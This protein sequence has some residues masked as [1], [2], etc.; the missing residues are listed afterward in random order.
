MPPKLLRCQWSFVDTVLIF[1]LFVF[2]CHF[3]VS[4]NL[5]VKTFENRG[6]Q[7]FNLLRH[8]QASV[9]LSRSHFLL[10]DGWKTW[11]FSLSTQEINTFN[12]FHIFVS[13]HENLSVKSTC[14]KS[15]EM[16]FASLDPDVHLQFFEYQQVN[17][18]TNHVTPVT[19][20]VNFNALLNWIEYVKCEARCK[21]WCEIFDKSN[22]F[23]KH[24]GTAGFMQHR[25]HGEQGAPGEISVGG[26]NMTEP[27]TAWTPWCETR[28]FNEKWVGSKRQ[29]EKWKISTTTKKGTFWC[30]R[31]FHLLLKSLM[32]W[33]IIEGKF[34]CFWIFVFLLSQLV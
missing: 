21:D 5:G 18:K 2:K 20:K 8:V 30:D 13:F 23:T 32:I 15:M 11:C 12:I 16:H 10:A 17:M 9:S 19:D 7:R 26:K 6:K 14:P 22:L 27:N 24:F 33:I 3:R 29:E 31:S 28:A 1:C 34:V 25:L 4:N